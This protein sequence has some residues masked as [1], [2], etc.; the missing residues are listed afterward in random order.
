MGTQAI[1]NKAF[2]YFHFCLFKDLAKDVA[3]REGDETETLPPVLL[4]PEEPQGEDGVH[5]RA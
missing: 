5:K 1:L 3:R 2:G 4:L